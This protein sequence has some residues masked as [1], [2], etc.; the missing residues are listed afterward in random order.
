[1]TMFA[2]TR[3]NELLIT[4]MTPTA[5]EMAP[6]Q[7]PHISMTFYFWRMFN[8]ISFCQIVSGNKENII[9]NEIPRSSIAVEE[10]YEFEKCCKAYVVRKTITR[11]D[12]NNE[13]LAVLGKPLKNTPLKL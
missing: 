3:K 11:I 4:R 13:S 8:N 7:L 2:W 12:T 9:I 5:F 1:M 10:H 6:L